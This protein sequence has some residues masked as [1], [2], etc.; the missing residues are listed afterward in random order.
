M[1]LH[2]APPQPRRRSVKLPPGHKLTTEKETGI[3]N[4]SFPL[5]RVN[6]K[7]AQEGPYRRIVGATLYEASKRTVTALYVLSC[8]HNANIHTQV[9]NEWGVGTRFAS[10]VHCRHEMR[11]EERR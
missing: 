6:Q 2:R 7:P 9:K 11:A 10:C 8:G 4:G 5:M 3:E 1:R